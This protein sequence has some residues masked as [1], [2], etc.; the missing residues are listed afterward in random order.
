MK[1]VLI[2]GAAGTIGRNVIK[3]L[4][5][6]GKYEI[7][8][9]D[10]KTSCNKRYLNRYRKRINIVYGDINDSILMESLLKE[11]NYVIHLVSSNINI[12]N[13]NN[14]LAYEVEFKG[15]ENIVRILNFY[16]P[17]CHLL[18]ASSASIYGKQDKDY[19]TTSTKPNLDDSDLYSNY[20]LEA[21]NVIRRKLTNYSI[22]RLPVVL[23]NPIKENYIFSYDNNAKI[24]TITDVDVAY[25][26]SRAIDKI[27]LVNKKIFN[28]GGGENCRTT[29]KE[30]NNLMLK[31]FGM[32]NKYFSSRLFFD[33]NFYSY[34][35]KDS[36]KLEDL[37]S[38]RNDSISSYFLR[39]KRRKKKYKVRKFFAKPF[40]KKE[41]LDNK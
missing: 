11:M 31:N 26:F 10:L 30:L 8:A 16:N 9:L 40:I 4:L 14:N 34:Y 28:V 33:K 41:K 15:T 38:F 32:N 23:C 27:N 6:E 2:T 18:Y 21:E 39:I 13:L 19:V 17:N 37:L 22:Y 20:K 5:S 12:A 35:F 24:E 29:G 3:Y 7:T 1:K 25:M 36:D